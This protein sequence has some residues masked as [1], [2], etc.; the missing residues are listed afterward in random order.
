LISAAT[1]DFDLRTSDLASLF[2][3]LI[4]GAITDP[5]RVTVEFK[6]GELAFAAKTA[7]K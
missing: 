6:K 3:Q 5:S 2:R 4:S 1:S 7:K